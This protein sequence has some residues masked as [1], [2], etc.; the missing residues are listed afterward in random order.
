MA[1]YD[2]DIFKNQQL[3]GELTCPIGGG[4]LRDPVVDEC[5]HTFCRGCIIQSLNHQGQCPLSR[6]SISEEN[7]RPNLALKVLL[8]T[9]EINCETLNSECQWNGKLEELPI[10]LDTCPY[11]EIPCGN[12]E[13]PQL[14]MRKDHEIHRQNCG[15]VILNCENCKVEV[16]KN[17]YDHHK[18]CCPL[19]EILCDLGCS[20]KILR[21][22]HTTH[23]N[24]ECVE[25]IVEC[26]FKNVGCNFSCKFKDLQEHENNALND[27]L[28][29]QN[30]SISNFVDFK[31]QTTS[32]LQQFAKINLNKGNA[33]LS[34][35]LRNKFNGI[36]EEKIT[37]VLQPVSQSS[38]IQISE[39]SHIVNF[40][41]ENNVRIAMLQS[42]KQNRKY[43]FRLEQ[44][45]STSEQHFCFGLA[46][47]E[48]LKNHANSQSA[49]LFDLKDAI[50]V[51]NSKTI[52]CSYD[53]QN[54]DD[55]TLPVIDNGD[56]V[57]LYVPDSGPLV[58][59]NLTK[60]NKIAL[61]INRSLNGF[62]PFVAMIGQASVRLMG[63]VDD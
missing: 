33:D 44:F 29:Y 22:D 27:H 25:R 51:S 17:R 48:A 12:R 52:H 23:K 1:C 21:K 57:S 59:E 63:I 49:S 3:L 62:V 35:L 50:F 7:L 60:Q 11:F 18:T 8:N 10:H 45:D 19:G 46:A 9:F 39:N 13:C 36:Y 54:I 20:A 16:T 37:N 2:M 32:L 4:I 40:L 42:E 43:I 55:K 30:K 26:E 38:S 56:L 58:F 24:S 61:K 6:E 34:D 31:T 5:G 53:F 15:F 28:K 14:V 41:N 47:L